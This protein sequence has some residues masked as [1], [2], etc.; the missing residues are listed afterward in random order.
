MYQ[1]LHFAGHDLVGF[2]PHL[3]QTVCAGRR[4]APLPL[5]DASQFV[6]YAMV[7]RPVPLG[8]AGPR[9]CQFCRLVVETPRHESQTLVQIIKKLLTMNLDHAT[10][11]YIVGEPLSF[12]N[13][14]ARH[15][16]Q[17]LGAGRKIC[18]SP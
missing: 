8:Q 14:G 1:E 18:C 16:S 17:G 15:T 5:P 6:P 2:S 4:Q 9:R 13:Q 7:A 12:L 11:D 3:I 10:N